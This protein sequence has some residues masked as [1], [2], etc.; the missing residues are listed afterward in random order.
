[1]TDV[2][3]IGSLPADAPLRAELLSAD[4]LAE[5]AREVASAQSSTTAGRIH[6]TPLIE[7]S[8]RAAASLSADKRELALVALE[9]GAAPPA[10]E[11]LLDNYYLIEEQAQ[12]VRDDLPANYGVT[13]PRLVGGAY[14][15]FPR[16]YEA[17]LALIAHTDSRVDEDALLH[18]VNGYQDVSPLTI[19]EVWAVPIVLRAGIIENLRRLSRE[20]LLAQRAEHEAHEWA[21]RL[22]LA[23]QE[24]PET[25]GSLIVDLDEA[26]RGSSP[27]FFVRFTQRLGELETGGDAVNAW[28]ERRLLNGRIVLEQASA[29]EQQTQA[30]NQVSIANSI[31]SIRFFD[32]LDWRTFF[33]NASLVEATLRRDP[34]QTYGA[35]DFESRDRYRHAVETLASRSKMTEFQIADEVVAL[36]RAALLRDASD[37]VT[38]HV[39]W[40]LVDEGRYELEP[41]IGYRLRRRERLY[42][43]PLRKH[44]LF[45]WGLLGIF[46]TLFVAVLGAYALTEGATVAATFALVALGLVPMSELSWC[47]STGS[48]R[49][50]SRRSACRSSTS[51]GR[52][53]S[54]RALWQ[55]CRRSC[56]ASRRPSR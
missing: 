30:A 2:T 37:E 34:S 15:D 17:L 52:S 9:Q 14:A 27:A 56:P 25:I 48:P 3:A 33:E 11:W 6:T 24:S 39:G 43:G 44:G 4:R 45:Y 35:M 32:A 8:A 51:V 46:T 20:V 50:C 38:G 42:R 36:S 49:W 21:Q 16:I 23:A 7:M 55:W 1:M 12:L 19:G 18:F 28:L 54:R 29:D 53:T 22:V 31:T 47:S 41:V 5:K 13:L 26:T 10:A 40:W